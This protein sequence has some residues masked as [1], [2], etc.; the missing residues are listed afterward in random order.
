V[1][2][3]DLKRNADPQAGESGGQRDGPRAAQHGGWWVGGC[4]HFCFGN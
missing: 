1:G 2:E 4:A 3:M